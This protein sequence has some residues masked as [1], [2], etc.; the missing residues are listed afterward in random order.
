MLSNCDAGE[1][2]WEPLDSKEIKPV[3]PVN[4]KGNQPWLFI[5]RTDAEAK[6]PIFWPGVRQSMELQ[7]VRHDLAIE[8]QGYNEVVCGPWS[9]NRTGILLRRGGEETH[10]HAEAG[11]REDT[12]EDHRPLAK[13]R[14]LRRKQ[15]VNTRISDFSLWDCEKTGFCSVTWSV[16]LSYSSPRRLAAKRSYPMSKV[17]S[18]SC[19]YSHEEIPHVQGKRNPSETVGAEKGHQRADRLKP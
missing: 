10:T 12:G 16:I 19:T 5:G 11:P 7:R 2:S 18:S 9:N 6:V 13:G 1:D 14:G 17:R 3:K 4:P 15:P 8:Q